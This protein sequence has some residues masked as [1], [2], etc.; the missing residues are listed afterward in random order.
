MPDRQQ[1]PT[2]RSGVES[3]E[4]S[5]FGRCSLQDTQ[6]IGTPPPRAQPV[7]AP[8]TAYRHGAAGQS[9]TKPTNPANHHPPQRGPGSN[10]PGDSLIQSNAKHLK[11]PPWSSFPHFLK[12]MGPSPEVRTH[13]EGIAAW[14]AIRE[15]PLRI[16][17][18]LHRAGPRRNGHARSLH[19]VV[20]NFAFRQNEPPTGRSGV[21][22]IPASS[23]G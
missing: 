5:F 2:G 9:K 23:K 14:R 15:S 16:T 3:V 18:Q 22:V 20:G 7:G 12:E 4:R 8:W 19:G 6:R 11:Q 13:V 21:F 10:C 17:H 1:P